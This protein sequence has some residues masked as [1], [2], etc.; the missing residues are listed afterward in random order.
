MQNITGET[1]DHLFIEASTT[2]TGAVSAGA[3]VRSGQSFVVNGTLVGPLTVEKDAV[4]TVYG[5]FGGSIEPGEGMT[6][7]HGMLN[8]PPSQAQGYLAVGIDSVILE[9]NG[10]LY[11]LLPDGELEQVIGNVEAGSH[12]VNADELC[13]YVPTTGK[14]MP[15]D[16]KPRV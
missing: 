4:C 8:T 2:V 5:V 13:V 15:V 1:T 10:S 6:M 9:E 3:T 7:V 16:T 14:F 11:T 12:T